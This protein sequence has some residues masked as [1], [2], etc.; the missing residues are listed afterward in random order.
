M[1]KRV[2]NLWRVEVDPQ[3]L[4]WVAGPE[5]LTTGLGIDSDMSVSPDGRKLAFVT[6]T[7]TNRLWSLP[8]DAGTQQ[9]TTEGQPVTAPNLSVSSLDLSSN[10]QRLA[11]IATRP[12]KD[13]MELW[14]KSFD[15]G[16]AT[17]LSEAPQYFAPRL[18]RD[19][20]HVAY[21]YT[22]QVAPLD[23][24]LS[25]RS[26]SGGDEH[27]LPK[28]LYTPWDWSSDATRLLTNCPVTTPPGLC[29]S[30]RTARSPAEIRTV[31]ADPNYNF[32]QGRF[33]PD[34]RWICF[35]AQNRKQAGVSIIGVMPASGGKWIPITNEKPW[36]DKPRWSPDGR[37][38]YFISNRQSAF[39]DIWGI[40]FDPAS[41]TPIGEEFRVTRY[42]NP[43]RVISAGSGAE[44]GISAT[45]LVVPITETSGSVWLLDN[46]RR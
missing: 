20:T 24:T 14:Y 32:Y 30:P 17:L 7:D 26:V 34:E 23:R 8:F 27:A 22:R 3:T 37:T 13:A 40:G 43:G 10:G 33:S 9:L 29:S 11:F 5:R 35:N 18:S 41:G 42:E 31:L 6:R 36:A 16:S 44:I 15:D 4:R 12:G 2:A 19:G 39:F 45:R 21:R 28:P 1:S 46:I 25:W 38:I